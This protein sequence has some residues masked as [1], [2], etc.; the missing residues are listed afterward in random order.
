M[1][2]GASPAAPQVSSFL[3]WTK[4]RLQNRIMQLQITPTK[5]FAATAV[6]L[7]R[8]QDEGRSG[9]GGQLLGLQDFRSVKAWDSTVLVTTTNAALLS[10][11][12]GWTWSALQLPSYVTIIYGGAMESSNVLW[13]ATHESPLRSSDSS[14]TWES[15]AIRPG[16]RCDCDCLRCREPPTIGPRK[17]R[18]SVYQQGQ[19]AVMASAGDGLPTPCRYTNPQGLLAATASSSRLRLRREKHS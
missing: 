16:S 12:G 13:V 7:Y 4:L 6:G 19:R 15:M 1:N 9:N 18:A 2:H 3:R 11:D 5:W 8:S 17:G 14:E 10:T